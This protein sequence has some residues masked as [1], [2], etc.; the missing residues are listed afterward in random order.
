MDAAK[1]VTE[2]ERHRVCG[3]PASGQ[4]LLLR[5]GEARRRRGVQCAGLRRERML[6]AQLDHRHTV[7]AVSG[8]VPETLHNIRTIRALGLEDYMER[9]L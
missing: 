2:L 7:A 5:G 3:G 6:A 8:Q 1:V 4:G 9:Q